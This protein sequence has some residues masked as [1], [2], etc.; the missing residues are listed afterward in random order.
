[1]SDTHDRPWPAPGSKL[2]T[3]KPRDWRNNACLNFLAGDWTLY[4]TGYRMAG[5]MLVNH[6]RG[7]GS[8]QDA[9]V[10]PIVF[11]YRQAL[12]LSLKSVIQMGRQL[13]EK[14]GHLETTHDLVVL[15]RACRPILEAMWPDD[16]I[17]ELDAVEENIKE[18]D[19]VD[20]QAM[21]FR[22]PVDTKGNSALPNDLIRLNLRHFG[23]QMEKLLNLLDGAAMGI[24]VYL[25][26]KREMNGYLR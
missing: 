18:L 6:V 9:L 13:L 3:D 19:A 21:A 7:M 17:E 22:Y 23:E 16:P 12:E 26:N 25:E 4:V 15:W 14:P 8:D 20:K 1:M 2:F 11:S 24:G 10:Y 5:Q